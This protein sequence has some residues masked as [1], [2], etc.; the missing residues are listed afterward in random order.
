MVKPK[1]WQKLAICVGLFSP[2]VVSLAAVPSQLLARESSE[3]SI[4]L[5]FPPPPQTQ[6]APTST[7]AGGTRGGPENLCIKGPTTALIPTWDDGEKTL[8][9]AA[10]PTFFVH[11]PETNGKSAEFILIDDNW[12][13]VYEK[14]LQLPSASG[15]VKLKLPE[16]APALELGKNYY[17]QFTIFC[18]RG[19]GIDDE[20]GGGTIER[21]S[22]PRDLMTLLEELSPL[23]QAE[24]YAEQRIWQ[25]ALTV[26]AQSRS[27]HETE[28]K[29]LLKSVGLGNISSEP[30]LDCCTAVQMSDSQWNGIQQVEF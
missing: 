12:Q 8:T 14:T 26:M 19:E 20:M 22:L 9:T 18:D 1:F 10:N 5:S 24:V 6:G 21:T 27:G 29:E 3:M 25:D 13:V 2:T 17:W 16:T 11:V 15:V 28:W 30:L 4:A 23:E 7:A